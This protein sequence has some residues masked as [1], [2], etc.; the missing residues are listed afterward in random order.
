MKSVIIG[1]G[2]QAQR[3]GQVIF[4]SSVDVLLG[5]FSDNQLTGSQLTKRFK[6]KLFN[7]VEEFLEMEEVDSVVICTPPDSHFNYVKMAL[8]AGKHVLVEKPFT[9]NS[10]QSRMLLDISRNSDATLRVGFN[11]RFH[12]ALLELKK[13]LAENTLGSIK[14]SRCLYGIGLRNEYQNEWRANPQIAAGGQFMEQGSHLVD[15]VQFLMGEIESIFLKPMNFLLPSSSGEDSGFA[16]ITHKDGAISSVTS[17]LL[18]WHNRFSIEIIGELGFAMIEGLGGSYG[19]ET[20][21]VGM[22]MPGQPFKS[23]SIEFRGND[24]SWTKEW[25]AFKSA[26]KGDLTICATPSESH[27]VMLVIEAGYASHKSKTEITLN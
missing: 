11:H 6:C 3:R 15:L 27:Q 17:T 16:L 23:E 14:F 12:P 7:S 25:D 5:V 9:K 8:E 2:L 1:S 21:K 4:D 19:V 22:N 13:I 18:Q 20:L 24:Q 26:C 10:E